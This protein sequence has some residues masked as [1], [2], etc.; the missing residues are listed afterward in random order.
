MMIRK[1]ILLGLVLSVAA[2]PAF[3][4]DG[5]SVEER[6]GVGVGLVVGGVA[7]GPIGA[8]VGAEQVATVGAALRAGRVDGDAQ[9]SAYQVGV[10]EVGRRD[11]S[12]RRGW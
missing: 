10:G 12:G 9:G 8:V 6:A 5:A 2:A 3:A 11:E 1:S 7:G 4:A